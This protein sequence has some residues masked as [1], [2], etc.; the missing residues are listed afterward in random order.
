MIDVNDGQSTVTIDE[1]RETVVVDGKIH[2]HHKLLAIL[3]P[4]WSETSH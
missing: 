3:A 1:Q 2:R 4:S